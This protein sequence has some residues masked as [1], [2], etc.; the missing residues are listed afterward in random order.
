MFRLLLFSILSFLM[1]SC[2]ESS[3]PPQ[4]GESLI[5]MGTAESAYI[6]VQDNNTGAEQRIGLN[7]GEG[8]VIRFPCR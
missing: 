6:V 4:E 3:T 7:G 1:F 2:S 5:R 8:D